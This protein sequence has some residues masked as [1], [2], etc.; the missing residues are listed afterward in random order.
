[1]A[2]LGVPARMVKSR[3]YHALRALTL[4]YEQRGITP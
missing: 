1:M 3:T 4:A 2:T